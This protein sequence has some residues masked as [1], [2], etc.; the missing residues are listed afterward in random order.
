MAR[1]VGAERLVRA[2]HDLVAAAEQTRIAG[3]LPRGMTTC[4]IGDANQVATQRPGVARRRIEDRLS[5]RS[6]ALCVGGPFLVRE[7]GRRQR[8]AHRRQGTQVHDDRGEVFV[9]QT[10]KRPVPHA[11]VQGPAV[12][13][14]A[15]ADR[16]G[17][18]V[19]GPAAGARFRIRRDVGCDD[20]PLGA[21]AQ[22]RPRAFPAGDGRRTGR[23]PVALRMADETLQ[24]VLG[25][26]AS[27]FHP[28]RRRLERP[29][30]QRPRPRVGGLGGPGD[31]DDRQDCNAEQQR[32]Q[33]VFDHR[34][35]RHARARA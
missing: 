14:D 13:P 17:E 15:L 6:R 35:L 12:M 23:I 27:T 7:Q 32:Q 2:A 11:P 21:R 29:V 16:P 31:P 25:Q 5:D 34:S 8:V 28:G 30:R 9:R 3:C 18:H 33:Q 22:H 1:Q 19:V 24:Q 4:A 26:V 10:R 20:A